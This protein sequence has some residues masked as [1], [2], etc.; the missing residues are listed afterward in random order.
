M[1]FQTAL[2]KSW[3]LMGIYWKFLHFIVVLTSGHFGSPYPPNT[4]QKI[5]NLNPNQISNDT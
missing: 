5:S 2:A 3:I 1:S 4:Q